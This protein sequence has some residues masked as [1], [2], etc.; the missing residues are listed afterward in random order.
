[1]GAQE[2]WLKT[3]AKPVPEELAKR[4]KHPF[5]MW[6]EILTNA[7]A[8]RF[9]KGTDIFL[10]KFHGLFYVA[11]NQDAFMLRL[12]LP[13]GILSASQARGLCSVAE[14]FGRGYLH[15]TTRA[16]L[17]IREIGATHPIAV[18]TAIDELG[19][20][21]RGAGADN[22]RNLTGSPAAGIMRKS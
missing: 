5:D 3:G 20:T 14:R 15:V 17:Q 8:G 21:S 16:N 9:P 22:I 13:G 7:A 2:R 11:P 6:D 19:L 18:L 1:M 10:H 12:R 4:A